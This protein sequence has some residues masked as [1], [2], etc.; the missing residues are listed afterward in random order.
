MKKDIRI[1][2]VDDH[3]V[4]R[5]GLQRMLEQE[6]DLTVVGQSSNG[7]DTLAKLDTMSH[8]RRATRVLPALGDLGQVMEEP[9]LRG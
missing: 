6:A 2:V 7:E 8:L 4:V 9:F 3:Q 5:D 1:L